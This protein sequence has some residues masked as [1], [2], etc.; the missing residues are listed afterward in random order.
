[1]R[2]VATRSW[3]PAESNHYDLVRELGSSPKHE[4]VAVTV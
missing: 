4:Q 3:L 1:V 2:E